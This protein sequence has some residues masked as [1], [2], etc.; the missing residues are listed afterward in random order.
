MSPRKGPKLK[1]SSN[2]IMVSSIQVD[3]DLTDG[4]NIG[5]DESAGWVESK[6]SKHKIDQCLKK[7]G[8]RTVLD[9]RPFILIGIKG[10]KYKN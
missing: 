7:I 5:L 10:I 6:I 3:L 8:S 4:E 9:Y 1:F 2:L